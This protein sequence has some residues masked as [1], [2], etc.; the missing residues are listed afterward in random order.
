MK[1]QPCPVCFTP[2]ARIADRLIADAGWISA[3]CH[4]C[5]EFQFHED[6][7]ADLIEVSPSRRDPRL[8][9]AGSRER[10]NASGHIREHRGIRIDGQVLETLARLETPSFHDRADKLLRALED[11]T[12]EAGQP[13]DLGDLLES[14]RWLAVAWC[15]SEREFRFL[16]EYLRSV[17]RVVQTRDQSTTKE[18]ILPAGF[19]Y[20][21]KLRET[22]PASPEGFVAMAFSERMFGVYDN[23]IA[24]AIA[25]AGYTPTIVSRFQ[26]PADTEGYTDDIV[27]RFLM[28]IRRS[29]FVVADFTEP[30]EGVYFEAGFAKGLGRHVIWTRNKDAPG[31]LHFDTDHFDYIMWADEATLR[32]QLRERIEGQLGPGPRARQR[33][34]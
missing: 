12:R 14:S 28:L 2:A 19:E 9:P 10:A 17:G 29:R 34:S 26:P 30:S 23:A 24:P 22:N 32:Q 16:L 11:E 21:E 3:K 8:G 18:T 31:R 13:V 4:R 15:V 20:L 27:A 25:E 7:W 1:E 6:S 33:Q 5:G